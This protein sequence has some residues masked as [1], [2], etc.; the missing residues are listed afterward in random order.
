MYLIQLSV[1]AVL[2]P[3]AELAIPDSSFT[4]GHSHLSIA[5]TCIRQMLQGATTCTLQISIFSQM[6]S[7]PGI[8]IMSFHYRPFASL[9]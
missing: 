8:L 5:L 4:P 6:K 9:P 2:T 7:L 1:S 3:R